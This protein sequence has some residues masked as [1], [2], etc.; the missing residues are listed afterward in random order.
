M[1]KWPNRITATKATGTQRPKG[2]FV[3]F[4]F[5]AVHNPVTGIV[6]MMEDDMGQVSNDDSKPM[7]R[8]PDVAQLD[9]RE[10]FDNNGG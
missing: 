4:K 5:H 3:N 7:V 2:Q 8:C 1:N 9:R 10:R 6:L